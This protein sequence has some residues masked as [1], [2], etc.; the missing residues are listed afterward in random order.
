MNFY[1]KLTTC[2]SLG[3]FLIFLKIWSCNTVVGKHY[4]M[5]KLIKIT[6]TYIKWAYTTDRQPSYCNNIITGRVM[7]TLLFTPRLAL[8]MCTLGHFWLLNF[9]S[10]CIQNIKWLK[11]MD[12]ILKILYHY[13]GILQVMY[14]QVMCRSTI[15]FTIVLLQDLVLKCLPYNM[16]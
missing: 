7:V 14:M 11:Q 6:K 2:Y 5:I 3:N 1:K 9:W 15:L 13:G 10:L 16:Y 12:F 8:P 4:Y